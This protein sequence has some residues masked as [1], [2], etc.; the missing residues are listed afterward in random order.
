MSGTGFD[1][2]LMQAALPNKAIMGQAAYFAAA[3]SNP[4]PAVVRFRITVDG[5]HPRARGG[6]PVSSPTTR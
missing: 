6:S 3:L 2:Q 1:A 5:G 4:R